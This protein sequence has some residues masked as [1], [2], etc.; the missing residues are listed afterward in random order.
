MSGRI[1]KH[2]SAAITGATATGYL[3]VASTAGFYAGAKG[4]MINAGQDNVAVVITEVASATSLGI[5]IVPEDAFGITGG[6]GNAAPNYG[7]SNV[8]AYNGGT[9]IQ[10]EQFIFNPNDKPLD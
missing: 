1:V 8:S 9:I 7:R 4:A 3:T 6:K 2:V 5:R 10:H